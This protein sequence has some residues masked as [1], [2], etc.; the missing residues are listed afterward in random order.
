MNKIKTKKYNQ[1]Y[2]L[3][4]RNKILDNV[5]KDYLKNKKQRRKK[6][7]K[8]HETHKDSAVISKQKYYKNNK[9]LCKKRAAFWQKSNYWNY[10]YIALK[11]TSKRKK[12]SLKKF[13]DKDDFFKWIK[14]TPYKCAYCDIKDPK[15]ALIHQH[16]S[17][18]VF[19]IDRKD[20]NK[21][22]EKDNICFAC[23]TCNFLKSSIFSYKE[24]KEIAQ[25]FIKPKW[26]KVLK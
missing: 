2:Y 1:Q 18:K 5:K 4:H 13:I 19:Q 9:E 22:Y 7:K 14:L 26:K 15:L 3:S 8:W 24:W 23:I 25:K 11:S 6:Q 21:G 17:K 10:R 20:N 12:F 16:T